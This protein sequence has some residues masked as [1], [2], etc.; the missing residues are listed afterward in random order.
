MNRR[1]IIIGD[2][3]GGLRALDQLLLRIELR[4]DDRLIFLGDYVDGWSESAQVIDKLMDLEHKYDC[5]FLRGNH[6]IWCEAFLHHREL[7]PAWLVNG[8]A[9]TVESYIPMSAEKR[10]THWKFFH[11]L[12]NY[13]IDESNRLIV[14]AG[15]ASPKGPAH[16]HPASNC[17][18]DR[19][20]WEYA[21]LIDGRLG[22]DPDEY[23]AR[24][25]L[26]I[27]IFIGHTPTII[28]DS[29]VPMRCCN[30]WNI[31]TGAAFT[32]K[33]SAIDADSKQV[34]QSDTVQ[35]LYPGEVGRNQ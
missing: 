31:D 13:F 20:L 18:W 11:R 28:W 27:E 10:K 23:P 29:D 3:H 7:H 21:M 6:D 1:T 8:G 17:C 14:H 30:V 9:S 32:G 34:W 25:R 24:F 4:E 35:K 19:T 2:I 5:V 12:K 16:E 26:F 22:I 33:L 15:F